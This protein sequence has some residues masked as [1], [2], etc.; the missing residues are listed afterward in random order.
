MNAPESIFTVQI[1]EAEV[2]YGPS[3]PVPPPEPAP[4][5]GSAE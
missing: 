5:V 3:E 1:G 4:P 2:P